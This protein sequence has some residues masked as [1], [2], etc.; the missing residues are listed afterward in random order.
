MKDFIEA[1]LTLIL[2]IEE[3][4]QVSLKNYA[5]SLKPD[6]PFRKLLNIVLS[7]LNNEHE[8]DKTSEGDQYVYYK[9]SKRIVIFYRHCEHRTQKM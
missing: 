5:N 2:H 1:V 4:N 7:K 3:G 8:E 6:S 9:K